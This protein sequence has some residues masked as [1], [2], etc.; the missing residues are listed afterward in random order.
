MAPS[1]RPQIFEAIRR[2]RGELGLVQVATFGTEGTKSAIQTACR[3]YRHQDEN[4]KEMYPDGID[5]DVAQYLSSLIPQERGFLWPIYDVVYGNEQLKR[6]PVTD[7]IREINQYDGLL[8][9]IENIEGVI[10]Q[11][12]IHAS[13]VM[14]YDVNKLYE[15][16]AIMRAPSGDLI[17]A[18]D[19]HMAEL[20]GDTKYDFLV[21]EVSDK[22]IQ[23]LNLMIQDRVLP[24]KNLRDLYNTYLHPEI[25]D[26]DNQDI[27]Q[28]LAKGSVLDVFQFST[29][30]GLAM[31]KKLRPTNP[32]E[33]TAANA[34]IRLMSEPGVE[35]QQDRYYRIKNSGIK[36]FDNEMKQ[37]HLPDKMIAALHKQCDEYYGCVPVQEQMM[38]I[39]MDPDIA[40]FSLGAA[41][42]ARKIVAKKQMKRIPELRQKFYDSMPRE[43]ADYVWELAVA[44]Q[45]GYA[46]SINHSLPYSF[47][48]IQ[49]LVLAVRYNPVYW[50]TACLIVNSG[51]TDP[52][53][54]NSANY[55]KI[56][57]AIGDITS[58]GIIVKPA[59][60]NVSGYGFKPNAQ[61][62]E[63]YYG[64]KGLLDV[65]DDVIDEIVENR[66]YNSFGEFLIKVPSANKKAV[67]SLIKSG[68]FDSFDERKRIMAQYIWKTCDK[69]ARLNLQN[70]AT[71]MKRNMIPDSLT[72]EKSVYEFN[73]YLK[74]VCGKQDIDYFTLDTRAI[75][76]LTKNFSS[77]LSGD[78][79]SKK[80]WDKT[81]QKVMD[82][83][84]A[85][86]HDNHDEMLYQLNKVTFYDDWLKYAK[87]SYSA[88]EMEA[89]CYYY[90][91]HELAH[92]NM[93]KYNLS[94]FYSLPEEPIPKSFYRG[95]IPLY[96]LT[97]ICGT[98]IAKDKPK[99]SISFLT[100][101]GVVHIRFRKE[102]F[103]LFDKQIS[104]RGED[105]KKKV[106]EKSWF[107]RGSMLMI[108]GIRRGDDFVPKKYASLAGHAMY[109]ITEVK[110]NGDLVLQY[111]RAKGESEEED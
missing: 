102:Y 42:D 32:I 87:G 90:H 83:I 43:Y 79:L 12:G 46:F 8:S 85:Y 44:P 49:T 6:E 76:F 94:N 34:M 27:W 21:T 93:N 81:Y 109:K 53:A 5:V 99:S 40:H 39:L 55:G 71:L 92:V 37:H 98:V 54:G 89:S 4:G 96:N 84:R 16:S 108:S 14:L 50:N 13:G 74:D 31:A 26:T 1:K 41:N 3:G 68:A 62:G 56:A 65:G 30:V 19:L 33:M 101:E 28:A 11:R 24:N 60:I 7:F 36:I 59:D 67:V 103:A 10:K 111:E 100:T 70:M 66:P 82:K 15:T 64:L 78:K 69:K 73:R 48:G 29:G 61:S 25:L 45:L 20:S 91:E 107:N 106:L 52:E 57:K 77:L 9:I 80:V 75:N 22:I 97:Y 86:I 18:Y 35:S 2:E 105:G 51:A 110:A 63:I 72:F 88:W 58:R 23:T 38:M 95:T 104:Q 47:V 17:T